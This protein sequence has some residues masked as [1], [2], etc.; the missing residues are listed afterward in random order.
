M[1]MM[2][3]PNSDSLFA[4]SP[5][6]MKEVLRIGTMLLNAIPGEKRTSIVCFCSSPMRTTPIS[7]NLIGYLSVESCSADFL[8]RVF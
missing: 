2:T 3:E 7:T 1:K 8:L 5:T 6:Q 4:R